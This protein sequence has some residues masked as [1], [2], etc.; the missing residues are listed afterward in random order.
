MIIRIINIFLAFVLGVS[1][2]A[3]YFEP[4]Q[5]PEID[6]T[7][8][9]EQIEPLPVYYNVP[10][11]K[12][13]QDFIR[14]MGNAYDVPIELILAVME[15]ESG[16]RQDII[17]TNTNGTKDYGLMQINTVNHKWLKNTLNLDNML[18]PYQNVMAGIYILSNNLEKTGGEIE[19]AL[20]MY[21]KG[22]NGAKSYWD[23]G[24][25]SIAY[26]QII[27]NNY[28]KY[29][30]QNYCKYLEEGGYGMSEL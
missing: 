29:L 23:R 20:M 27:M 22:E 16:F 26:S 12:H 28:K 6:F 1:V 17:C 5:F 2:S 18:D 19:K 3:A 24:I 21:N 4:K 11:E 10:L 25:Y 13:F 14:T 8:E 7:F 30:E 15:L 9:I